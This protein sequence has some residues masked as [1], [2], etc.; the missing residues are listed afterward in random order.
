MVESTT[1]PLVVI[2]GVTGFLG[3]Q[4]L[5]EFLRG[6]GKGKYRVRATVR[7]ATK[8][9]SRWFN[10]LKTHFAAELDQIEFVSLELTNPAQID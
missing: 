9:D 2:T 7:D 10:A 1:K 4:V 5:N 3:S 8:T 6:E